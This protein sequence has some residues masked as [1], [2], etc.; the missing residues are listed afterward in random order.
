[1]NST[2]KKTTAATALALA[3]TTG[4]GHAETGSRGVGE[5][6][7][8]IVGAGA[9]DGEV[10]AIFSAG[11]FESGVDEAVHLGRLNGG[12]RHDGAGYGESNQGFLHGH[13]NDP[14]GVWTEASVDHAP[15]GTE[16]TA[17]KPITL[18]AGKPQPFTVATYNTP[19][20]AG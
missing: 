6:A 11:A 1:M 3:A 13:F 14:I 10:A 2:W 7:A 19:N 9:E 15:S 18:V 16:S 4:T 12:R 8:A 5:A 20:V 17:C